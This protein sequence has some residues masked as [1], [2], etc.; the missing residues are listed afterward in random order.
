MK[1]RRKKPGLVERIW[2][3]RVAPDGLYRL[4]IV[5]TF[6]PPGDHF[7]A[8]DFPTVGSAR[9][10]GLRLVAGDA[11]AEGLVYDDQGRVCAPP[12]R[13]VPPAA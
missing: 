1:R 4:L 2:K 9:G 7:M 13:W 3:D 11:W 12:A 5:D 10:E 8:G 6:N